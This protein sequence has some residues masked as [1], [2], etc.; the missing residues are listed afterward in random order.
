MLPRLL[1]FLHTI[2]LRAIRA[3]AALDSIM[4]PVT[5]VDHM[6]YLPKWNEMLRR[7]KC[8]RVAHLSERALAELFYHLEALLEIRG[9]DVLV[10]EGI[11][12]KLRVCNG[13]ETISLVEDLNVTV[14]HT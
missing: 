3:H 2:H 8:K 4:S 7:G 10:V 6:K 5:P 1:Q 13:H 12:A 11:R 9:V 14:R